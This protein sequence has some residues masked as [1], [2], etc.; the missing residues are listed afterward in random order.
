MCLTAYPVS[1]SRILY[2]YHKE[3]IMPSR[4]VVHKFPDCAIYE[5]QSFSPITRRWYARITELTMLDIVHRIKWLRI[6]WEE[7]P[8]ESCEEV[9]Q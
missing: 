6:N 2:S 9:H 4:V 7:V 3:V 5:F 8:F 1:E